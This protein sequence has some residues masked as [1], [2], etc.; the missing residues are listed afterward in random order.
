[1]PIRVALGEDSLIV[2]EGITRLLEIDEPDT[3]IEVDEGGQRL[4]RRAVVEDHVHVA[5]AQ[6]DFVVGHDAQVWPMVAA[7]ASNDDILAARDVRPVFG[8]GQV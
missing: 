5:F 7:G 2:R 8:E 4:D 1:M 6:L 3:W